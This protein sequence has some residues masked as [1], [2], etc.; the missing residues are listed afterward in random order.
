MLFVCIRTE[1]LKLKKSF[2]WLACFVIPLMPAILGTGNY[3]GNLEILEG[4]WYAL[5]TQ[6]TLF[7]ACFFFA[8]LISVYCAWLWRLENFGHNRNVLMTAPVPLSCI[9]L[10]KLSVTVIV[11]LITQIWMFVLFTVSGKIAG[12]DGLPPMQIFLWDMRSTLGG[13]VCAAAMLLLSMCIR[14]FALPIGLSLVLTMIGFL[15]SNKGWGMFYPFSLIAAGMNANTYDDRLSGN[16]LP[17]FI[18]CILYLT[19]FCCIAIW[20]LRTRDVKA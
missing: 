12:L 3:L 2:V 8:P 5:W 1:L 17:F 15:F 10:G 13:I 9:F 18:S 20:L 14:S 11:T 4:K 6:H 19:L 7:Y 16:M